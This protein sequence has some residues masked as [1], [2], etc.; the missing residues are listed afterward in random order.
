MVARSEPSLFLEVPIMKSLPIG[1]L[2]LLT[3]LCRAQENNN[4]ANHQEANTAL[5]RGIYH[6]PQGTGQD[7]VK[8]NLLMIQNGTTVAG[9]IKEPN[10]FGRPGQPWLHSLVR[11]TIDNQTDALSL[12]KTYDGTGGQSHDVQYGGKMTNNGK[13]IEGNW[14]IGGDLVGQFFLEKD[15]KTRSGPLSGVWTGNYRYGKEAGQESVKFTMLVIHDR[16]GISGMIKEGN[17]FGNKIEPWL[18]A[19]IKGTFDQKTGKLTFTKTYDGSAGEIHDVD[20]TGTISKDGKK[21]E[22]TWAITDNEAGSFTIEKAV[23]NAET[24]NNLK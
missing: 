9:F 4:E 11:G 17:G 16:Q 5:W 7:S 13:S 10:S 24:L 23:L 15:A 3:T 19:G 14:S 6:Y 8:F 12:T 20:Y 22:G 18:H 21:A 2:C 1:F